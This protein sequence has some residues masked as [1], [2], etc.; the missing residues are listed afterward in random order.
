MYKNE[1]AIVT[2]HNTNNTLTAKIKS[3][4]YSGNYF[5]FGNI[6]LQIFKIIEY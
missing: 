6:K 3:G 5:K 1:I 2:V 4:S